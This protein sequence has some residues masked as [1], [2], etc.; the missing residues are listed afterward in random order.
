L[1]HTALLIYLQAYT[2]FEGEHAADAPPAQGAATAAEQAQ[3]GPESGQAPHSAA[4]GRQGLEGDLPGSSKAA[5]QQVRPSSPLLHAADKQPTHP[6]PRLPQRPPTP[7]HATEISQT[8]AD[9]AEQDLIWPSYQDSDAS[10]SVQ[11]SH[12]AGTK[13]VSS[14][15]GGLPQAQQSSRQ[16]MKLESLAPS[17]FSAFSGGC[18]EEEEFSN[19]VWPQP[20]LSVRTSGM[21][22]SPFCGPVDMSMSYTLARGK[23]AA[24]VPIPGRPGSQVER[25]ASLQKVPSLQEWAGAALRRPSTERLPSLQDW[26]MPSLGSSPKQHRRLQVPIPEH[27]AAPDAPLA[28]SLLCSESLPKHS[29]TGAKGR[30]GG[31]G[32]VTCRDALLDE[33]LGS[34]P[35]QAA[36]PAESWRARAPRSPARQ[37]RAIQGSPQRL[38]AGLGSQRAMSASPKRGRTSFDDGVFVGSFEEPIQPQKSPRL[39]LK[40]GSESSSSRGSG[41]ENPAAGGLQGRGEPPLV[42]VGSPQSSR[43]GGPGFADF[44]AVI[45]SIWSGNTYSS[46]ANKPESAPVG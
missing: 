29:I 2:S 23:A 27:E 35:L 42:R 32:G 26:V 1:P 18:S 33:P 31:G 19:S 21:P 14:L 12:A 34:S 46:R 7:A 3:Q 22:K 36:G 11:R 30:Q 40:Q 45:D 10:V 13:P 28:S 17:P 25:Q 43:E 6:A 15:S 20:R 41:H 5:A 4:T 8:S 24:A 44:H 16:H 38:P 39:Q 9:E 37:I